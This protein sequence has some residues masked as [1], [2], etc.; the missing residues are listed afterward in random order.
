MSKSLDKKEVIK[1]TM[2]L[3]IRS[4]EIGRQ[5]VAFFEFENLGRYFFDFTLNSPQISEKEIE[6]RSERKYNSL[7]KSLYSH[8]KYYQTKRRI[9]KAIIYETNY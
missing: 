2:G 1:E 9:K 7:Q 3:L 6:K 4:G 8:N 5:V